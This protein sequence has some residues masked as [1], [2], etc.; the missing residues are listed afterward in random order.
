MLLLIQR[1]A[2]VGVLVKPEEA[3]IVTSKLTEFG[4][5]AKSYNVTNS[6]VEY[7]ELALIEGSKAV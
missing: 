3:G 4:G 1:W 7:A 5:E 2:A 6:A